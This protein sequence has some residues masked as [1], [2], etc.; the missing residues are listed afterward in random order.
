ME[1]LEAKIVPSDMKGWIWYIHADF[2]NATN[3]VSGDWVN[4]TTHS[5]ATVYPQ[6][7]ASYN[8]QT[9]LLVFSVTSVP[10]PTSVATWFH[11]ALPGD[12]IECYPFSSEAYWSG[13]SLFHWN[14]NCRLTTNGETLSGVGHFERYW[15]GGGGLNGAPFPSCYP[16]TDFEAVFS[17]V[18]RGG[19]IDVTDIICNGLP[20]YDLAG[21]LWFSNGK[22]EDTGSTW[23][24]AATT[25]QPL[26]VPGCTKFLLTIPTTLGTL[27]ANVTFNR[28]FGGGCPSGIE[29]GSLSGSVSFNGVSYQILGVMAE[30]RCL[31]GY[32]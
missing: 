22:W 16:D 15:Q 17:I 26:N 30:F 32:C 25:E 24:Q 14:G 13:G 6:G 27:T 18:F 3:S 10:P 31:P 19:T 28:Y 20:R 7:V 2:V 8:T 23:G 29:D 9:H 12:V 4:V 1:W 11:N 5:N 21:V